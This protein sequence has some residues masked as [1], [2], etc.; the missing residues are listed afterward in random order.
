MN[1]NITRVFLFFHS[2]LYKYIVQF[3]TECYSNAQ[4]KYSNLA[5]NKHN[6]FYFLSCNFFYELMFKKKFYECYKVQL[7]LCKDLKKT[8]K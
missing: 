5:A 4:N 2:L 6:L 3:I 7:L 8:A 1:N